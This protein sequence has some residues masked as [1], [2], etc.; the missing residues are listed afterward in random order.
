MPG[1]ENPYQMLPGKIRLMRRDAGDRVNVRRWLPPL[2]W[3][4]VILVGT[5]LPSAMV[6]REV[7]AFDK[8]LHFTFYALFAV[9]LSRQISE[10]TGRW[11][12]AALAVL[13]AVTFGA[14]D[15][16]HQRFI[17]GRS[18]ELADWRADSIGAAVGALA[19]A[20]ARRGSS[21]RA[22]TTR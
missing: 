18:T 3:A 17:P 7:S 13:I 20:V 15:E 14:V 10:G 11:S 16:W 6:P 1:Q 21:P 12:A 22:I 2:L 19:F 4:G 8:A 5:S 9:L